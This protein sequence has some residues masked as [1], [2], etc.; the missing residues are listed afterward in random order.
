MN[1]PK[2]RDVSRICLISERVSGSN[3]LTS[4]LQ[5]N[6]PRQVATNCFTFKHWFQSPLDIR[7][8]LQDGDIVI[9]NFRNALDWILHL[10]RKPW[11]SSSHHNLTL[12][13]FITKQ[14]MANPQIGFGENQNTALHPGRHLSVT[15]EENY[16]A[17]HDHYE[18]YKH[19]FGGDFPEG[20]IDNIMKLRAMKVDNFV[21]IKDWILSD[22]AW[23]P[24]VLFVRY[25]D[26]IAI[27]GQGMENFIKGLKTSYNFVNE[28]EE[29]VILNTYKGKGNQAI[30]MTEFE[31]R[32]LYYTKNPE[33]SIITPEV[34]NILLRHLDFEQEK[35]LGYHYEFLGP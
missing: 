35:K 5:K 27:G 22:P 33:S 1:A 19:I 29:D 24:R 26:L 28:K 4:T 14:W 10:W 3:W 30:N 34:Q 7:D 12:E 23:T 2:R 11:N 31:A 25:E 13:E 32:E 17:F 18:K 8:R 6:F 16:S 15:V 9:V 20:P 21:R